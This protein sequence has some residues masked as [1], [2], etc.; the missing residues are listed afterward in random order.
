[1]REFLLVLHFLGLIIGAGSGF[2]LFFISLLAPRWPAAERRDMMIR[3]FPLRY[4]SYG[5]LLLLIL[6]GGALLTPYAANIPQML[7]LKFA[8]VA[9][10]VG[11]A[12][13]GVLCMRRVASQPSALAQLPLLGK[14]SFAASVLVVLCA[15]LA[16]S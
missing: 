14:I 9:V 6:S 10:I 2:A 16:F 3:L 7:W 5:G 13:R 11:C 8:G 12:I 4:A 15:V 1:M